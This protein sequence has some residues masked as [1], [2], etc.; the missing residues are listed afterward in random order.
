MKKITPYKTAKNAFTALDNGGRFYNLFSKADDGQISSAEL[1]KAAGFFSDRQ[2]MILFCDM[3]LSE[4]DQAAKENI[5]ANL[6][7]NLKSAYEQ[8]AP[9]HL[10]PS[11][12]SQLG[13]ISSNAIITGIPKLIDSKTEFSGFIMV[14]I[15]AGK[16]MTFTMIPI[17]EKYEVYELRDRETDQY[18]LLAHQKSTHKLPEE[19][20]RCGGVLKELKPQKDGDEAQIFLEMLY[21]SHV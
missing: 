7:N 2:K 3:S 11:E 21:Y 8:Y 18:F 19:L 20:L 12:A 15:M 13:I 4:L 17:I 10:L 6:S 9:Q 14:P 5:M 16:V 1:A